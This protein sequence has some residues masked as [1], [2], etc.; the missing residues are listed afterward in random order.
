MKSRLSIALVLVLVPLAGCGGGGGGSSSSGADPA[1]LVPASAPLYAEATLRP[2]GA[3]R[4]DAEAAAKKLLKTD[5]PGD[6]ITGLLDKALKNSGVSWNDL[7]G[8]LGERAGVFFTSFSGAHMS[9]AVI[10]DSTDSGKAKDTIDKGLNHRSSS[11]KPPKVSSR[12]YKGVDYKVD[13]VNDTAGGIVNGYAVLGS[14]A[15]F[16]QVVDTS[17]GGKNLTSVADFNSSR[18]AVGA[19]DAL[20]H[21]WADPQ[22]L[23]DA[24]SQSGQ[25]PSSALPVL[26]QVFAQL[27]RTAAASFRASGDAL[28]LD[29]AAVGTPS[30]ATGNSGADAA[31][32]LPSDAWLAIGFGDLGSTLRKALGQIEQIG[33]LGAVDVGGVMRQFEQRSGLNLKRDLLSWMGDGAF[34]ARGR[35]LADIGVVFTAKS[36]NAARSRAAAKKVAHALHQFG[37]QVRPGNVAGYTSSYVVRLSSAP[38]ALLVASS[39]DRFS[40]G[41]NPQA[42]SDVAHPKATLGDAPS[43]ASAAKALGAGVKPA[44]LIDFPTVVQLLESFGLGNNPSYS[45]VKPYLDTIGVI[46]AG[47][48]HSGDSLTARL[49]VALR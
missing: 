43:Y 32:A 45:K 27:G 25:A 1:K 4:D 38:I 39:A 30:T 34:Y 40:I 22:T 3:K 42:L 41:V 7:K 15:G 9:G 12:S 5:N 46:A 26:R 20:A 13:T 23:L 29:A 17:K 16:K 37:A 28:R 35:S 47:A 24:V 6:K 18:K 44:V 33:S 21:A 10:F 8:W 31:A 19:G 2:Q 49:A 14:E 36:N 11:E 48:T